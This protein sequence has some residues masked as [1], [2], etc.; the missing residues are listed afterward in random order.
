MKLFF[1]S[2]GFLVPTR[3]ELEIPGYRGIV[4]TERL[5]P[6]IPPR[7]WTIDTLAKA[8]GV[9]CNLCSEFLASD[10]VLWDLGTRDNMAVHAR[11]GPVFVDL[12]AVHSMDEL[13]EG[14]F[15]Y[16]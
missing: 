5:T 4:E 9:L 15:I 6:F 12:G 1:L 10:Q 2:P 3:T 7:M 16:Y 13:R 14:N 8:F 11:K